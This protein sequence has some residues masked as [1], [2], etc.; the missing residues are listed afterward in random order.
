MLVGTVRVWDSMLTSYMVF[1][2]DSSP[3]SWDMDKMLLVM[4]T[5]TS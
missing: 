3:L 4:T 2:P 1:V 5:P